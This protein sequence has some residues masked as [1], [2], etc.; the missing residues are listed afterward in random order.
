M[1]DRSPAGIGGWL[2]L[3]VIWAIFGICF[4][5]Y[6]NGSDLAVY[7]E[8]YP[9]LLPAGWMVMGLVLVFY[10]LYAWLVFRLVTRRQGIVRPIKLM[11]IATP[12]FNAILPALF[13]LFLA[14]TLPDADF[15]A[16]LGS[17]YPAPIL[18]SIAGAAIMAVVWYR[19]FKVSL[20]VRN[21]WPEG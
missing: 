10:G 7:G 16:I 5:I 11:I 8:Q 4:A 20:R 9:M 14:I 1:A 17:A 2:L 18:G 13:A 21:T 19:Y 15:M 3:Y 6:A 12:V